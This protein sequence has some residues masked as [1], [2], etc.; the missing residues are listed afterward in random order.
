[1]RRDRRASS[2]ILS[3]VGYGEDVKNLEA[4]LDIAPAG[5]IESEPAGGTI[6]NA[7]A[8]DAGAIA[9]IL[10]EAFPSLYH[11]TFGKCTTAETVTLLTAL[12]SAGHLSMEDTH[13][14]T[15]GRRVEGVIILHTGQ[16]IGRGHASD[17]WRVLRA[18]LGRWR[19]IRAYTGGLTANYML[20]RRIPR[21]R[22]LVYIEALAVR[23]A[24]R[25][26]GI[27]SAL[28]D[29]AEQWARRQQRSRLALHVLVSN[30]GARR[31]YER[32]GFRPWYDPATTPF[33]TS[34]FAHPASWGAILMARNLERSG[35]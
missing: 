23:A 7:A 33:L 30:T 8:E 5:G 21:A 22:D 9:E 26:Q 14:Y 19:A 12:Y 24:A 4:G 28:L 31:L 27:G 25:G 18:H 13:L 3:I 11:G 1:M 2:R 10:A 15:R 16:S 6:R 20:D 29:D 34:L 35:T 17:F 32:V